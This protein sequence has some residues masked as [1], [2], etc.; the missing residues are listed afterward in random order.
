[1]GEAFG[2]SGDALLAGEILKGPMLQVAVAGVH[3]DHAVFDARKEFKGILAGQESVGRIVVDPEVGMFAH[4]L[5]KIA[6][7]VYRL[8]KSS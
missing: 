8:G 4:R 2:I 1:M 5:Q 6:E 7:D 3:G